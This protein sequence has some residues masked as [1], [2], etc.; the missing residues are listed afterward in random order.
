MFS[1]VIWWPCLFYV[2][3]LW[4]G[5][6]SLWAFCFSTFT[7]RSEVLAVV[8]SGRI[9][10]ALIFAPNRLFSIL[11]SGIL[12]GFLASTDSTHRGKGCWGT[13]PQKHCSLG[14]DVGCLTGH[15]RGLLLYLEWTPAW[16]TVMQPYI[17]PSSEGKNTDKHMK[18]LSLLLGCPGLHL[19]HRSSKLPRGSF[20]WCY[21]TNR[22]TSPSCLPVPFT[23]LPQNSHTHLSV[24]CQLFQIGQKAREPHQVIMWGFDL[25]VQNRQNSPRSSWIKFWLQFALHSHTIKYK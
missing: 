6:K 20:Q 21:Q 2:A 7:G 23:A 22:I 17:S 3:L 4:W 1:V 10:F 5:S 16:E 15:P 12:S 18:T 9:I 19:S 24:L 8:S 25:N 14:D 11:V 13:A